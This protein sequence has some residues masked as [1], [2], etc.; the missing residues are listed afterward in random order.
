[1]DTFKVYSLFDINI[2]KGDGCYVYDNVGNRY[3]DLYGGHAVIL[4]GHSHP[5][6]IAR[7]TD[8]LNRIAFYS[9]SVINELQIEFVKRLEKQCGYPDY[10]VFFI[11]SGAEA[12]EN[13]IKLAS[14]HTGRKKFSPSIK[15]STVEPHLQFKRVILTLLSRL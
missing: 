9:N 11:N 3:L 1:M 7:V 12:I 15:H 8:Q 2:V 14:F 10:S 6:Y 13:A 4:I 5:H